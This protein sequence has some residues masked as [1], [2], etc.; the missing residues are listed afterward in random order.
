MV[1]VINSYG[2]S[3]Q[4]QNNEGWVDLKGLAESSLLMGAK[5]VD[6]YEPGCVPLK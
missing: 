4:Q 6:R 2:A 1:K 3:W 5:F